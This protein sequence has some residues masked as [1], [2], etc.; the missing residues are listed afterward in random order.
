MGTRIEY[1]GKF[2]GKYN[3]IVDPLFPEDEI[4]VGYNGTNPMD[5]GFIYCP[6]IPLMPLQ[7]ITDP[8]TFQP[9]K[10]IMTRYGKVAVAPASRFYRVIRLIGAGSGYVTKPIYRNDRVGSIAVSR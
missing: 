9:R 6:Y 10:G 4:I 5:A 2:A 7:T 1:R 3:L 8:E